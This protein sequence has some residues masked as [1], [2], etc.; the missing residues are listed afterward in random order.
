MPATVSKSQAEDRIHEDGSYT[1]L[2][3][4]E[5]LLVEDF[6]NAI[7][8]QEESARTALEKRPSTMG[9]ILAVKQLA[10]ALA[11]V[12]RS[13]AGRCA[14]VFAK[15]GDHD[16]GSA[17]ITVLRGVLADY[18][19]VPDESIFLDEWHQSKR[20]REFVQYVSNADI[21]LIDG[22]F[23]DLRLPR[24]EPKSRFARMLAGCTPEPPSG[25]DGF[26]SPAETEKHL[27]ELGAAFRKTLFTNLECST[28]EAMLATLSSDSGHGSLAKVNIRNFRSKVKTHAA[29]YLAQNPGATDP[30]L[31][32]HFDD[33]NL[34]PTSWTSNPKLASDTFRKV[35]RA[36]AIP[37]RNK[38]LSTRH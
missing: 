33:Y 18:L 16:P 34:T 14:L 9:L 21:K 37:P 24:W 8:A 29:R 23:T 28:A 31:R 20:F 19:A 13:H 32:R 36:M 5:R 35:R 38:S 27:R 10:H 12:C 2:E 11:D 1:A 30:E 4:V 25:D 7:R 3:A 22:E 6:E 15:R 26:L 17:T